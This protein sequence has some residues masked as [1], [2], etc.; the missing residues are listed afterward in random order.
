M[1]VRAL[2]V[3]WRMTH[4]PGGAAPL[5][6]NGQETARRV[7]EIETWGVELL[8]STYDLIRDDLDPDDVGRLEVFAN[9][10]KTIRDEMTTIEWRSFITDVVAPHPVR[11]LFHEDPFTRHAFEKPRGYPGDAAL[12]DLIYRDNP[13]TGPLSERGAAL[14]DWTSGGPSVLSVRE[15]RHRLA[16]WIDRIADERPS[17]RILSVACGHLREAQLSKAVRQHRVTEFIGLDQDAE[18]VAVVEREQRE[19]N[20]MPIATSS[21][22][23]LVAPRTWGTFDFVYSAGL[24]DYLSEPMARGL[25]ASMFQAV[26]PG[27]LLLIAN[28]APELRD[29]GYMEAIMDWNLIYRDERAVDALASGIPSNEIDRRTLFRDVPGNVV[30]LAIHKSEHA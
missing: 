26:R 9:G 4:M 7:S 10:L 2:T 17:P 13:F 5:A 3:T 19:F 1:P 6:R 22:R 18:T 12:L 29:I 16:A 27:G 8:S 23:L 11:A 14:Y 21:R 28:F 25:T 15:R 30:Y 20:V 24:Y